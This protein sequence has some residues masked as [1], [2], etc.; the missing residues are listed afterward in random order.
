MESIPDRQLRQRRELQPR[1]G[2]GA[3]PGTAIP[4]SRRRS[5]STHMPPPRSALASWRD[6][7]ARLGTALRGLP[8]RVRSSS[9]AILNATPDIRE[10][11]QLLQDGYRDGARRPVPG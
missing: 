9:E 1:S 4:T 6:D 8:L 7:I 10:F 11:R 3:N 2:L 5:V